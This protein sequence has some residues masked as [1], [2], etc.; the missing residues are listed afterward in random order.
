[1]T[2]INSKSFIY[3]IL[4]FSYILFSCQKENQAKEDIPL[5]E[6]PRPDF[7]RANWINLNGYWEFEFDGSD[8]YIK[9][10]DHNSLDL[11]NN[12]SLSTWIKPINLTGSTNF[13]LVN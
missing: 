8:D 7:E 2:S 9:I 5:P 1:M 6:H 4:I 10:S 3:I 12:I 13:C 11:V